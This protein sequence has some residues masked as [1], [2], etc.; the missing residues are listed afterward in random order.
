MIELKDIT[1]GCC[2]CLLLVL[3]IAMIPVIYFALKVSLC[4]A[5]LIGVI[6]L[7]IVGVAFLGKVI[8]RILT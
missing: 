7:A 8:R 6:V 1:V 3:C 5:L 4:A 2:G